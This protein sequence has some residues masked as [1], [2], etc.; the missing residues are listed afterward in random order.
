RLVR[1]N[2][3]SRGSLSG[4]HPELH[5]GLGAAGTVPRL[6]VRWPSGQVQELRD[7]AAGRRL[8]GT[9]TA[10]EVALPAAAQRPAPPLCAAAPPAPGTVPRQTGGRPSG[11]VQELR[12]VAADRRLVSTDPAEAIALPAAAKVPAPPL[13]AA[14]PQ[15]PFVH[16]EN[17]FDEYVAQPLLPSGV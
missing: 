2:W 15:P 16:R 13:F 9:D 11:Q 10:E 17:V 5:F 8:V 3:L 14:A 6:T 7:V 12:D 4:Q 1:E